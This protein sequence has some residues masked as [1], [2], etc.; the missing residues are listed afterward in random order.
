MDLH[1]SESGDIAVASS[2]DLKMTE[3]EW[4]DRVQQCYVRMMTDIGDFNLSV[5]HSSGTCNT[6]GADLS[7]LYGMPQSQETGQMG[8]ALIQSA[9]SRNGL[10]VGGSFQ[11]QAVP[12]DHDK[13]RF[14]VFLKLGTKND[15]RLSVEQDLGV[16]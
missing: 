11:V 13:I 7:R 2:G 10:F 6:L 1:F 8:I 12:T 9:L 5:N 16:V 3:G 14:D 15:V 4:R